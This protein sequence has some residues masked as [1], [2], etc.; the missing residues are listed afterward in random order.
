MSTVELSQSSS[1]RER[2]LEKPIPRFYSSQNR[3]EGS[4]AEAHSCVGIGLG[5]D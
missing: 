2:W 1:R 4:V 3:Q 5:G